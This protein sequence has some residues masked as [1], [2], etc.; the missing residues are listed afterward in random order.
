MFRGFVC[1]ANVQGLC[2]ASQVVNL[3]RHNPS[4][5]AVPFNTSGVVPTAK[6][7]AG[8]SILTL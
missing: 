3:M 5:K 1:E 4:F 8:A 2:S 6:D 7:N